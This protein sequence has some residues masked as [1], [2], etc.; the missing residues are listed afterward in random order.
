MINILLGFYAPKYS[1]TFF[2]MKFK[3]HINYNIAQ[4]YFKKNLKELFI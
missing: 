3:Y 2:R 4:W 1:E